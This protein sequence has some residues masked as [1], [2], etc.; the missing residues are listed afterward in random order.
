MTSPAPVLRAVLFDL[1][2]TLVDTAPEIADAL[3]QLLIAEGRTPLPFETI[4]PIV[5]A[6]T[7]ALVRLAFTD[8]T[9]EARF[10]ALRDCLLQIYRERYLIRSKLFAGMDTVLNYLD[11]S[12]L[13]FGIV[14]NK[15]GWLTGPLVTALGLDR[16]T[17]C[18]VSGDTASR[19]KPHPDPLLHA[20]RLLKVAADECVYVGDAQTDIVA[21]RAAGMR[22]IAASYGY[23]GLGEMAS[24]WQP[25]A[26]LNLPQDLCAWLTSA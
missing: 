6:G 20:A 22:C 19:A 18:I 15:V 24:A 13:P 26:T 1:D 4:R 2:G 3:N 21:G 9:D 25:N 12:G 23:L 5:S 16:R 14:T 10:I 7:N 11:A 8:A 17:H